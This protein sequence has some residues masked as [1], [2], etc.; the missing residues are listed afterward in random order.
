MRSSALRFRHL[1][2]ADIDALHQLEA[3]SY[4]PALHESD[5]AFL[6]LIDLFP[7]GAFGYFDD[8]GLCGYGFGVPLRSGA[9]LALRS[10]LDR[11]PEGADTFYIHDVAVAARCRG[12]GVGRRLA[13]AL[14]D[15]AR[16][17][18]FRTSELVS[19]QGSSPFWER[20]GFRRVHDLEYAPGAA[21]VKM[22]CVLQEQSR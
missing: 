11:V 17:R 13:T 20:F 21:S 3:E 2:S 22:A 14:L 9:T 18:G 10:P 1:T 7:E 4:L 15:L 8:D 5:E 19:V 12:Q 16:A 6:R